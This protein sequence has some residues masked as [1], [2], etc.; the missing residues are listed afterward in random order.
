MTLSNLDSSLAEYSTYAR[1]V[2]SRTNQNG[3]TQGRGVFL[4]VSHAKHP[5]GRT[6]AFSKF[7]GPLSTPIRFDL[8]RPNWEWNT[9]GGTCFRGSG[10]PLLQ[11]AGPQRHNFWDLHTPTRYD[12]QQPNFAWWW[13]DNFCRSTLPWPKKFC[14]TNVDV[15]SVCCS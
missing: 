4:G 2:C 12:S 6:P 14:D 11:E 3:N 8:Q 13:E 1:I 9:W 7:W 10:T 15:Q 5:N